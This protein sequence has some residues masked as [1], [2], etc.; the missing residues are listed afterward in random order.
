[1]KIQ[2]IPEIQNYVVNSAT[3]ETV[4]TPPPAHDVPIIVSK[5]HAGLCPDS[6]SSHT[7]MRLYHSDLTGHGKSIICDEDAYLGEL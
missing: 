4:Y 6:L 2:R 7:I 3:G 1:M 5:Y